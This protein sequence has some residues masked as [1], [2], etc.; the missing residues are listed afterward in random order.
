MS[1]P[2]QDCTALLWLAI[3][4]L[5]TLALH[6]CQM[7]SNSSDVGRPGETTPA[8]HQVR[9]GGILWYVDYD[10]AVEL[11]RKQDKSLWVHF[12]ENPG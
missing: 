8:L 11:A 4:L 6:G 9:I 10:A 5:L 3:A 2:L 12:G 1:L 7:E